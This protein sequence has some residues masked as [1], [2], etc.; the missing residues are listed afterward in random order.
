MDI[1]SDTELELALP[2]LGPESPIESNDIAEP[3]TKAE[4]TTGESKTETGKLTVLHMGRAD[5]SRANQALRSGTS[6]RGSLQAKRCFQFRQPCY[7]FGFDVSTHRSPSS[8]S[9]ARPEIQ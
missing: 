5:F 6:D 3:V 9:S 1:D 4:G 2:E 7:V 8:I